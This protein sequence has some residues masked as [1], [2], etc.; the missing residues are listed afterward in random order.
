[1]QDPIQRHAKVGIVHF[2]AHKQTMGGEGPILETLGGLASDPYFEVVEVTTMK[3]DS[4]RKRARDILAS[5]HMSVAFGAQPILLRN[6]LSLNAE[7]EGARRAAVDAMKKALKEAEDLGAP[8]I[9]LL[10]GPDPGEGGRKRA[11]DHLVD[12]LG[13]IC[14]E[15]ARKNMQVVLETFDRVPFGKN[16][17]VGPNSLGV[18]VSNR[19]RKSHPNFGL[20][21]DLSH[22]PLQG[23]APA[24]ALPAARDHLVHAH[25]GNCVMR[26]PKHPAYGD[27][28]P[29]FGCEDG[30]N[31]VPEVVEFLKTLRDIGYLNP[32]ER[33][34]LSFE[35]SPMEGETPEVVIA[36]AKRVLNQAWSMV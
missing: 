16:C 30:E 7:D 25:I 36:N 4:V 27:N 24:E 5:A 14:A 23:E 26:N 6:K 22:L 19:V 35:V 13:Q 11:V 33:R 3:D 32:K 29:R 15:A 34:I 17:L 18:E 10:S 12:S 9:A 20:M 1:M 21:L 31:D 2:M 28:H 8:G